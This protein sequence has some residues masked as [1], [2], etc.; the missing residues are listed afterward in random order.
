MENGFAMKWISLTHV[1]SRKW[2]RRRTVSET[3]C[4]RTMT[5]RPFRSSLFAISWV[6]GRLSA[7][8][9]K[10][11]NL[12]KKYN[13][14]NACMREKKIVCA[15][16]IDKNN[17][18]LLQDRKDISKYWEEWSFFGWGIEEGEKPEQALKRE[19]LEEL[20]W[21][22]VEYEFIWETFHEM[23]EREILYHR[24]VYLVRLPINRVWIDRE[25]S[26]A[27]F[28]AINKVKTLIFNTPID[29]ELLLLY[30]NLK[31]SQ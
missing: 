23:V 16:L 20:N 31:I 4:W 8:I 26:G 18:I 22:P 15:L 10:L 2:C 3:A 24:Y 28:F 17:Q 6:T 25:W 11:I 21:S 12:K 7:Q 27:H 5:E 9:L 13:N 19:I 29:S 1:L 14:Y 30:N